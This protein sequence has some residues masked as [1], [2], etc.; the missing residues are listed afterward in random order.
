MDQCYNNLGQPTVTFKSF[1]KVYQD[2]RDEVD[3]MISPNIITILNQSIV[4]E[5]GEGGDAEFALAYLKAPEL[6][7]RNAVEVDEE[8]DVKNAAGVDGEDEKE[9]IPLVDFTIEDDE[10]QLY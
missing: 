4:G 5:A 9:D 7:M 1:W 6:D 2:L 3:V 10:D 8:D